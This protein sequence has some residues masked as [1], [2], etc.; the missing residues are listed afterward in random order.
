M[1]PKT[2]IH[3]FGN[4]LLP[5]DNLPIKL[6]PKLEKQFPEI[7]FVLSDPNENIKPENGKLIIIDTVMGIDRV[8]I[9]TDIDKIQTEQSCSAHDFD[10]GFNLKLLKKIG[11]LKE[12]VIF[13]VPPNIKIEKAEKQLV[14]VLKENIKN[15]LK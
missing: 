6:M 2:K 11:E 13:C 10:L 8:K 15:T 5:F 3:I 12:V 4:P 7:E 9:L 14:E 1:K